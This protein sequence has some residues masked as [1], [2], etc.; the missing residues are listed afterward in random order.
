VRADAP[1]G[2]QGKPCGASHI[3]KQHKCTK[4][5]TKPASNTFSN[6]AKV[7]LAAGAVAGST[8][9]LHKFRFSKADKA[10]YQDAIRRPYRVK[11]TVDDDIAN[12]A[13]IGR[14]ADGKVYL[15]QDGK[16]AF[17][18][19]HKPADTLPE[20]TKHLK[21]QVAGVNTAQ[22][23]S[24]DAKKGII[25]M[26]ALVGYKSVGQI[27]LSQKARRSAAISIVNSY[28]K[29]HEKGMAHLD[30]HPRNLLVNKNGDVRVIDFAR[31]ELG[32]TRPARLSEM[33]TVWTLT[34]DL[35]FISEQTWKQG[36]DSLVKVRLKQL[37]YEE[38]M[39]S[40][41]ILLDKNVPPK[42][43]KN[44]PG[45]VIPAVVLDALKGGQGKPCGK[46]H[47]SK[48]FKCSAKDASVTT[49][50]QVNLKK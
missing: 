20:V 27:E 18:V 14:G 32:T 19:A 12:L 17:K 44:G 23:K 45:D 47:I 35:G 24:Y 33:R 28:Q 11:K 1:E 15:S 3:P 48:R 34:K 50:N 38:A 29:L 46:S 42:N 39:A 6:V 7:A 43:W 21:A 49:G 9:L 22:L 16:H 25:K 31:S 5:A 30:V 13:P 26:E 41:D 8:Y 36:L 10:E 40:I 4:G 2:G 37:S